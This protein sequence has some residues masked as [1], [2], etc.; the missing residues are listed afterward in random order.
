MTNLKKNKLFIIS[1]ASGAGK[2][3]IV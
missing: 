2:T 3:T 1:A